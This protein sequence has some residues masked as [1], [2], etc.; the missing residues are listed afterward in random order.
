MNNYQNYQ[1]YYALNNQN[2][3]NTWNM[4]TNNAFNNMNFNK[5]TYD[6]KDVRPNE[7]Y[8]PYAGFI[9]GNMFPDL[10]NQ[11]KVSKPYEIEP[12]NEQAQL[13]TN[14]DAISFA[15]HDLNLYLDT[16]PENQDI[17]ELYNHYRMQ[18]E[19]AIKEYE[20]RFG[21]LNVN[22]TSLNTCPWAWNKLPWPWE[23]K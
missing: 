4:P 22:S 20:K 13:L 19:E 10:Y 12:M 21:P 1:N 8:D 3:N 15:A 23:N 9:R 7:L 2:M 16:H 17:I 5:C 6:Q 18:S 11:Y 14:I